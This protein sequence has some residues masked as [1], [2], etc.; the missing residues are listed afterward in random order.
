VAKLVFASKLRRCPKGKSIFKGKVE[1]RVRKRKMRKAEGRLESE[2]VVVS[3]R[4]EHVTDHRSSVT[5]RDAVA[6]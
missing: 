1:W 5:S 6:N 2:E 3:S 4:E